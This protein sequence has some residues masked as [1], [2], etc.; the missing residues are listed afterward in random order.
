MHFPGLTVAQVR[1]GWPADRPCRSDRECPLHTAGDR[2]LWHAGGT[3][4]ENDDASHLAATALSSFVGVLCRG[5]GDAWC[6]S[7]WVPP[8]RPAA[9]GRGRMGT[10][11]PVDVVTVLLQVRAR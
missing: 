7:G 4:G 10:D 1:E 11:E 3:A 8:S 9:A 2:C 5:L 6:E